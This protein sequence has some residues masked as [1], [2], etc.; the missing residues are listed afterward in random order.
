MTGV[1]GTDAHQ[2]V[3]PLVLRDGERWDSYRRMLR[4][5]SNVVWVTEEGPDGYQ[6][7]LEAGRSAVVF[8]LLG[9]PEGF[10]FHLNDGVDIHE[11]GSSPSSEGILEVGCPTLLPDSPQGAE[12][13]EIRVEIYRDGALWREGCG[14]H[15][16]EG[17]GVYRVQ[18]DMTPTHLRDLL[19]AD[20]ERW[21]VPF[22]WI[23]SNAIR[24]GL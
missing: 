2:N 9:T 4:W 21:M 24:V 20:S 17:S 22:P 6:G 23:R 12:A 10:D 5:F 16:T 14:P 19:G 13:P 18:V 7:A 3:M 15:P 11:M 8:E 1:G